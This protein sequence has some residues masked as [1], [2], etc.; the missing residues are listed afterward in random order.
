VRK[1][2]MKRKKLRI[3]ELFIVLKTDRE[4]TGIK[5]VPGSS[6]VVLVAILL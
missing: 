3:A 1:G 4:Q 6:L 2:L 5:T